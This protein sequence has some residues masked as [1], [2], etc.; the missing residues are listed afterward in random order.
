MKYT[1]N[2]VLLKIGG[3]E[4]TY[5]EMSVLVFATFLLGSIA[6]TLIYYFT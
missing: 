6:G 2:K 5:Y 3:L 1:N 4:I